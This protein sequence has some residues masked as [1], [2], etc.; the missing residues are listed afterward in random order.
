V[1][2]SQPTSPLAPTYAQARDR[3]LRAAKDAGARVDSFVHPELGLEGEELA[4]DVAELGPDD[5]HDVVLVVSG[6][7][8][9]EGYCGS[10]LQSDWLERATPQRPAPV[11]VVLVH[12][13][14]PF[15]F[16]WV[17]RTN[18]DN[19]DLN[20]NFIDW[21]ATPPA[22][23]DYDEIADLLV[24]EQWTEAERERTDTALLTML[25]ERGLEQFQQTISRG[26]YGRRD[27]VFYGGTAPAWSHRWLRR[28]AAERLGAAR[29][30]AILDIHTGLGPW[31]HGELISGASP[32]E[33]EHDRASAWWDQVTSM[34]ADSVSA[35]L[36]G[37]WL[38]AAPDLLPTAEVTG[39]AIEY[40]TIDPVSVLQAL[41]ADAWLH[42]HGDPT[43]SSAEE[44]RAQLRAAFADDDPAWFEAVS[45]RFDQVLGQTFAALGA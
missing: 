35:D 29:R 16:S 39:V 38:Q 15:G 14:N 10:A 19:V 17:K 42:S 18:E 24:P 43:H 26:Q 37:D 11:A 34:G 13:L 4:I 28:W 5:A 30:L 2:P 33:P 9:V 12:A 32:G 20:R 8:G 27:G 45:S 31:G 44:V 1:P 21:S 36:H 25:A 7:H 23:P 3:F 6:T 40:G 22:T 41:R